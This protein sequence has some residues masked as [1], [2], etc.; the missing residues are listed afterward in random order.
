MPEATSSQALARS[1]PTH[2]I[3]GVRLTAVETDNPYAERS[4][5]MG[6]AVVLGG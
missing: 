5:L 3:I 6:T 4:V 2:V 1:P